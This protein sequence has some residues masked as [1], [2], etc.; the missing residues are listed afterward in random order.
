M[1]FR[2]DMFDAGQWWVLWAWEE[3]LGGISQEVVIQCIGVYSEADVQRIA[4][5]HV[6]FQ[7]VLVRVR[8]A[9]AKGDSM[10]RSHKGNLTTGWVLFLWVRSLF[11]FDSGSWLSHP[12]C[13]TDWCSWYQWHTRIE[14]VSLGLSDFC[15]RGVIASCEHTVAVV[16]VQISRCIQIRYGTPA[17]D[18]VTFRSNVYYS[19]IPVN[20]MKA[21]M[22]NMNRTC[23]TLNFVD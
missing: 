20:D 4:W 11:L 8:E 15:F 16:K 12:D 13:S 6:Y 19:S 9:T 21:V 7:S 14:Q 2:Q 5:I 3:F 1:R 22:P 23:L 17:V 10:A 18:T